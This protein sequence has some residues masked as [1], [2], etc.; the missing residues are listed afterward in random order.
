VNS[1]ACVAM[2]IVDKQCYSYFKLKQVYLN[3]FS[4]VH[5]VS[6][7]YFLN[8]I[9]GLRNAGPVVNSTFSY[10]FVSS[11]PAIPKQNTEENAKNCR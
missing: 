9:L 1:A 2:L 10:L 3:D 7:F 11:R 5:F 6:R 4:T 8:K